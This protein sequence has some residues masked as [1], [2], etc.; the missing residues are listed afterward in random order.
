MENS[1]TCITFGSIICYLLFTPLCNQKHR[2]AFTERAHG[3]P[4]SEV[5]RFKSMR[6]P[7]ELRMR[8]IYYICN[9]LNMYRKIDHHRV[10]LEDTYELLY[11]MIEKKTRVCT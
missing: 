10:N 9:H 6:I 1:H 11:L 7:L 5:S 2:T 3:I 4:C 8:F